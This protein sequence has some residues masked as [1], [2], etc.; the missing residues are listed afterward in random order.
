MDL[1]ITHALTYTCKY[2]ACIILYT[3]ERAHI[4]WSIILRTTTI[5]IYVYIFDLQLLLPALYKLTSA[6]YVYSTAIILSPLGTLGVLQPLS[7]ER[8]G[9][10]DT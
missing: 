9:Q 8:V 2:H 6:P 7:T 1:C 5:L 4:I 10:I 3:N